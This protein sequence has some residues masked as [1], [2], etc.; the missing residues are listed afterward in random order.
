MRVAIPSD[1]GFEGSAVPLDKAQGIA[2][3]EVGP[4][5]VKEIRVIK[6]G[7]DVVEELRKEKIEVLISPEIS[8]EMAVKLSNFGIKTFT[9]FS[10]R[11]R[12]VLAGT[13]KGMLK[14][15]LDVMK[16]GKNFMRRK[17]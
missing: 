17:L 13:M 14:A 9:G 11:V 12:D 1:G 15:G 7:K 16:L 8:K 2:V 10:G 5:G 3:A 4:D 6:P